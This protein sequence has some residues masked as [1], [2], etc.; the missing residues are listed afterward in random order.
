MSKQ[1]F[2]QITE[3]EASVINRARRCDWGKVFSSLDPELAYTIN[4]VVVL[5][6]TATAD[7][8]PMSRLRTR[9]WLIRTKNEGKL[10]QKQA[11]G[12]LLYA[13]KA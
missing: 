3:D 6:A 11:G 5:T 1:E 10:E 4:E 13:V 8:L 2:E 9:N 7:K 12:K